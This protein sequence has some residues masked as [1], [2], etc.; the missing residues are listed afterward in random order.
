M[1]GWLGAMISVAKM[2][3]FKRA[4]VVCDTCNRIARLDR[5]GAGLTRLSGYGDQ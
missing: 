4:T 2:V 1:G 3:V 5:G